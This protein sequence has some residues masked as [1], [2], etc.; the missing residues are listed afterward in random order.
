MQL[1]QALLHVGKPI[2]YLAH[3]WHEPTN[4]LAPPDTLVQLGLSAMGD[5]KALRVLQPG[6]NG[7]WPNEI[8]AWLGQIT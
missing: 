5:R 4:P 6:Q 3:G 8:P 2:G 1:I 7:K